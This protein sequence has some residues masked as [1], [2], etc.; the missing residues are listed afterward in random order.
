MDSVTSWA[1]ALCAAAVGCTALQMLAPKGGLGRLF[2]LITAAFFICCLA[3]PLLSMK[4]ILKLDTDGLPDE[5][6]ADVL[7]ERVNEQ[8]KEQVTAAMQKVAKETLANYGIT[9]AKVE[10]T[11]DTDENGSIYIS[12]ITIYLDKQSRY[13]AITAKQVMEQRL[14]VEVTVTVLD[15]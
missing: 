11:M 3:T 6:S 9:P 1:A 10:V 5:V 13:K 7:K 2:K 14:G 4:S 12:D 8:F 15:E